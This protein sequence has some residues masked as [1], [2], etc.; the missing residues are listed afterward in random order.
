MVFVSYNKGCRNGEWW[1]T[2][3]KFEE[4]RARYQSEEYRAKRRES[5]ARYYQTEEGHAKIRERQARYCQTE[6]GRA[7][8]RARAARYY[9]TEKGRTKH[10]NYKTRY[11]Q[12]EEGRI[13]AAAR[14]SARRAAKYAGQSKP[15]GSFALLGTDLETFKAH[16]EAQFTEGM[17]WEKMG[18]EIHIDHKIP[19][20]SGRTPEEIWGLC[21]Y[22]NLQPLWAEDNLRKG[23][24]LP[25]DFSSAT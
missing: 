11:Y 7:K 16:I 18:R 10:R 13:I 19:L 21:H 25:E 23:A 20:A 22:T 24:K 3:E 12:T 6:E 4:H 14:R 1:V 5:G 17:S 9:Q 2:P 15:H 8:Q